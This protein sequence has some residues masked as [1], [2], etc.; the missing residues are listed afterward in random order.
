MY[1]LEMGLRGG[2]NSG[3]PEGYF[4]TTL[5]VRHI[6]CIYLFFYFIFFIFLF[7]YLFISVGT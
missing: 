3:A 1:P 4:R 2:V 6:S 5:D 7:I